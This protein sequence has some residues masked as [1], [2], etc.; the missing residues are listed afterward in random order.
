M[1]TEEASDA[2]LPAMI[3]LVP[4]EQLAPSLNTER[5]SPK[6]VAF[7]AD[8]I[9]IYWILLFAAFGL[10][11]L[12]PAKRPRVVLA[13]PVCPLVAVIKSPKS[14]ALPVEAIVTY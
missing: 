13:M 2:A 6:S 3:P 14:V 10:I 9:V 8:A 12:P 5:R 7:P 4:L 1:T 11:S